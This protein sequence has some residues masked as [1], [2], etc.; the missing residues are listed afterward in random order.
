VLALAGEADVTSSDMLYATLEAQVRDRP[1][2]L[3][4]DMSA[5]RF[6]DSSALQA[7]LRA[8]VAL[9]ESGGRLALVSPRDVVAR[10]LEMTEADRLVPVHA[11]V[12]EAV[13][14]G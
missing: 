4:I 3:I 11:S 7:I 8:S 1:R 13:A 9:R 14:A 5:L 12:A 10:V 6:M 2:L